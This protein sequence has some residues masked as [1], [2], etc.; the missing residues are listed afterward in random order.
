MCVALIG[1]AIKKSPEMIGPFIVC[2][3]F[4]LDNARV[5]GLCG[6]TLLLILIG[7]VSPEHPGCCNCCSGKLY[8]G[9]TTVF[10][11]G[12]FATLLALGSASSLT[13]SMSGL[14]FRSNL[15]SRS[16]VCSDKL[17]SV[18]GVASGAL[19]IIPSKGCL[20][21]RTTFSWRTC[22][23]FCS[24]NSP[25]ENSTAAAPTDSCSFP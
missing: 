5:N 3:V 25:G 2:L 18:S 9:Q 22:L 11:S 20:I 17:P 16:G 6:L 13:V 4:P 14:A 24:K 15:P 8:S 19:S 10:L 12:S 23:G 21:T 1:S 7:T